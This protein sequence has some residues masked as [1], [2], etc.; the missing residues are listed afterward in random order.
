MSDVSGFIVAL[1]A[2]KKIGLLDKYMDPTPTTT[3]WEV[4]TEPKVYTNGDIEVY[5]PGVDYSIL[6]NG[7]KFSGKSACRVWFHKQE[8]PVPQ[9]CR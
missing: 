3:G 2:A 5:D 4:L 1:I 6:V 9:V 8:L 7:Q